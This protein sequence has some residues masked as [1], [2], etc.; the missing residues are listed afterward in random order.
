MYKTRKILLTIALISSGSGTFAC[1]ESMIQSKTGMRYHDF[2]TRR[3]ANILLYSSEA[4]SSEQISTG[5]QHAGH[6]LT[7]VAEE[8]AAVDALTSRHFDLIIASPKE[9]ESLTAH[10]SASTQVPTLIAVIDGAD[11]SDAARFP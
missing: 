7:V 3:P 10:L 8:P 1:G 4:D 9:M 5:L 11:K 2:S 6:H